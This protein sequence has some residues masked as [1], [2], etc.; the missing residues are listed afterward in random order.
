MPADKLI[1]VFDWGY[2]NT[3]NS[4]AKACID[5]AYHAYFGSSF[6]T[7]GLVGP[8][9]RWSPVSTNLGS[10]PNAADDSEFAGQDLPKAQ[11]Y[12]AFMFFNLRHAATLIRL[13]DSTLRQ[14]GFTV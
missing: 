1:T 3:L 12:G 9:T 11:G 8:K 5:Y 4:E 2:T 14:A 6:M 7:S 10:A 13:T